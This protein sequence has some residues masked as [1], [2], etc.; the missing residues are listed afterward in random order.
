MG[1]ILIIGRTGTN[2]YQ[3]Y[4]RSHMDT[5]HPICIILFIV[6][7]IIFL[8]KL[9]LRSSLYQQLYHHFK[10]LIQGQKCLRLHSSNDSCL[11]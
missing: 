9:F 10:S 11:Q 7:A 5:H 2:K 6:L 4:G 8:V 1:M 3:L